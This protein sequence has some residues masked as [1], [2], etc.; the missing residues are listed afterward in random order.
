MNNMCRPSAV[1]MPHLMQSSQRPP[2]KSSPTTKLILLVR[3]PRLRDVKWFT[4][5]DK[6][7]GR[8]KI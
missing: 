1:H 3:S 7:S 8:Y 2:H 6:A 4:Q 5:S